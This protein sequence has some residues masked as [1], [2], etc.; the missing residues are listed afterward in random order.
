MTPI[1][2]ADTFVLTEMTNVFVTITNS[3]QLTSCLEATGRSDN[4]EFPPKFMESES[5]VS[6][7]QEQSADPC[8]EP[9]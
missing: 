4:Q 9:D 2:T 7:K 6:N 5:S 1:G 3:T 8:P